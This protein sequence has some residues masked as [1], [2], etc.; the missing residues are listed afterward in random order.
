MNSIDV[1]E[2]SQRG[3]TAPTGFIPAMLPIRAA[4]DLLRARA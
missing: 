4:V 3:S 1:V 2:I